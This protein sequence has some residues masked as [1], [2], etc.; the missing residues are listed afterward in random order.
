MKISNAIIGGGQ[1]IYILFIVVFFQYSFAKDGSLDKPSFI[2]DISNENVGAK[3][4][5]DDIYENVDVRKIYKKKKKLNAERLLYCSSLIPLYGQIYKW[6]LGIDDYKKTLIFGLVFSG[7]ISFYIYNHVKYVDSN[8]KVEGLQYR[9][10]RRKMYALSFIIV[11]CL[12]S[13]FDSYLSIYNKMSD[14]SN[15]LEPNYS[16]GY[17]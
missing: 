13:V 12:C 15:S 4:N 6:Y 17:F 2:S 3:I 14:F 16:E 9:Y 7:L 10:Y 8:N 11:T 1:Y 5:N